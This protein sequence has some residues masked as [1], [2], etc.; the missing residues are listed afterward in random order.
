MLNHVQEISDEV[1]EAISLIQQIGVRILNQS[2]LLAG[3]NDSVPVL[4]DLYFKLHRLDIQAYYL[5]LLDKVN[6]AAHFMISDVDAYA[7]FAQ[8]QALM[9]GYMLP[10]L[11]REEANQAN[12]TL[13]AVN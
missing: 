9:P 5:H 4:R 12:K 3:V 7:L 6:G 10:K 8:L 2:V 13:L 11:A 1:E